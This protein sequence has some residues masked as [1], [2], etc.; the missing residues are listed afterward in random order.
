MT[1]WQ[2]IFGHN[3]ACFHHSIDLYLW[4]GFNL[5]DKGM[6]RSYFEHLW[7]PSKY[8]F[9]GSRVPC[10]FAVCQAITIVL[11]VFFWQKYLY[12][13]S[14]GHDSPLVSMQRYQISYRNSNLHNT[15]NSVVRTPGYVPVVSINRQFHSTELSCFIYLFSFFWFNH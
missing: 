14:F 15:Y 11:L 9:A 3:Y 7:Q 6:N 2:N 13:L 5:T 12:N 1:Y 4:L 10:W 8:L